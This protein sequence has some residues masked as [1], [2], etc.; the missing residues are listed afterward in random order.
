MPQS[1]K[2]C[3]VGNSRISPMM[4]EAAHLFPAG[5]Q[6]DVRPRAQSCSVTPGRMSGA[7]PKS[8]SRRT[9]STRRSERRSS[10]RPSKG[11]ASPQQLSVPASPLTGHT[12]RLSPATMEAARLAL[13]ARAE[14]SK[15]R[16]SR[17]LEKAA[18]YIVTKDDE[19]KLDDL[20]M[21]VLLNKSRR[22]SSGMRPGTPGSHRSVGTDSIGGAAG[23]W[24][25]PKRSPSATASISSG[26][27]NNSPK[28]TPGQGHPHGQGHAHKLRLS[29]FS[30]DAATPTVPASPMLRIFQGGGRKTSRVSADNDSCAA[31]HQDPYEPGRQSRA[32][33]GCSALSGADPEGGGVKRT[34]GKT[35]VV[36][37]VV[38]GVFML[39]G[40]CAF[41]AAYVLARGETWTIV[42]SS[43]MGIGSLLVLFGICWYLASTQDRIGDGGDPVEIKMVDQ[44]QLARLI[45]KGACVETVTVRV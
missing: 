19:E 13:A 1:P 31:D 21:A 33:E 10:G 29:S 24:R 5:G 27:H 20:E 39:S 30:S 6:S 35:S 7:S 12:R 8:R 45:K 2:E 15:R 18:F 26:S 28:R 11:T 3:R 4:P 22:E 44:S 37:L 25:E 43:V 36:K 23:G 38:A 32:S 16:S 42:G 14:Y 9:T 17:C 41:I 34:S 40:T